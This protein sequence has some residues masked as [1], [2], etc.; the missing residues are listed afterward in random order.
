MGENKELLLKIADHFIEN[1]FDEDYLGVQQ[2]SWRL[3]FQAN[4]PDPSTGEWFD[5]E[6]PD[7]F[8]N[9]REI[10]EPIEEELAANIP[11]NLPKL[12]EDWEKAEAEGKKEKVIKQTLET[13]IEACQKAIN[14]Q[15]EIDRHQQLIEKDIRPKIELLQKEVGEAVQILDWKFP[16]LIETS[17][18]ISQALKEMPEEKLI[19]AVKENKV[20]EEIL[21]PAIVRGLELKGGLLTDSDFEEVFGMTKEVAEAMG[22]GSDLEKIGKETAAELS[23]DKAIQENFNQQVQLLDLKKFT[24]ERREYLERKVE[25]PAYDPGRSF[26]DPIPLAEVRI[27]EFVHQLLNLPAAANELRTNLGLTN[28]EIDLLV[29][30]ISRF[31]SSNT[32]FSQNPLLFTQ[33]ENQLTASIIKTFSNAFEL[34]LR[35]TAFHGGIA[36]E[37]PIIGTFSQIS[38]AIRNSIPFLR[39]KKAKAAKRI[40]DSLKQDF[41]KPP[42]ALIS[43]IKTAALTNYG[44]VDQSIERGNPLGRLP[45]YVLRSISTLDERFLLETPL[46]IFVDEFQ[47]YWKE[48]YHPPEDKKFTPSHKA[49]IKSYVEFLRAFEKSN[50]AGF[51]LFRFYQKHLIG[52]SWGKSVAG[53]FI[54]YPDYF[55]HFPFIFGKYWLQ[56]KWSLKWEFTFKP[57]VFD[58]IISR[59]PGIGR[60]LGFLY[61]KDTWGLYRGPIYRIKKKIVDFTLQKGIKGTGELLHTLGKRLGKTRLGQTLMGWGK[62]L[63]D[64]AGTGGLGALFLAFYPFFKKVL[65]KILG[66]FGLIALAILRWAT[67]YGPGAIA[68][69]GIG[70][71]A[72]IPAGIK[73]GTVVFKATFPFLGPFAIIPSVLAGG[74]TWLGFQIAGAG[75]GILATKLWLSIKGFFGSIFSSTTAAVETA[76]GTAAAEIAGGAGGFSAISLTSNAFLAPASLAGIAGLAA[77]TIIT[78]SS[79]YIMSTGEKY[80]SEYIQIQKGF[81]IN[82]SPQETTIFENDEVI[83][84]N[85]NYGFKVAISGKDLHDVKVNDKIKIIKENV[86]VYRDETTNLGDMEAGSDWETNYTIT[87]DDQFRD[88]YVS[89]TVTVTSEEGETQS[90]TLTLTLGQ[91]PLPDSVTLARRIVDKLIHDCPGLPREMDGVILN[92]SSWPTAKACLE[93]ANIPS[94]VL[95]RFNSCIAAHYQP[96]GE[97]QCVSFVVAVTMG[98]LPDK[99]AAKYYC[100]QDTPGYTLSNNWNNIQPGDIIAHKV[101]T[102]GHVAIVVSPPTKN[103]SGKLLSIEVAE[104]IGTNGVVQYRDISETFLASRYCGYLRKN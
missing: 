42:A 86:V 83:G 92:E 30:D 38:I 6:N 22:A 15:W 14:A 93:D 55:L 74:L 32:F 34:H 19:Q 29:L 97:L 64:I 1:P 31:I 98:D 24:A 52:I 61:K 78:S 68:G 8:E 80:G 27:Q 35:R 33:P 100:T 73:V 40:V 96:R 58:A 17:D 104:A 67:T 53:F 57:K 84:Q 7:F 77:Y 81:D 25:D 49:A 45:S 72:G 23:G 9:I 48:K 102:T 16:Q 43:T 56:S 2:R 66:F 85:L 101:G 39:T 11:A 69:W 91:P 87:P 63:L 36:G 51:K 90:L 76:A 88:S 46:D 62:K 103:S 60:I 28:T 37:L 71:V 65:K 94:F 70:A 89:N 10:L 12:V 95:N 5:I 21:K 18:K 3:F 54:K 13:E 79:A 47:K 99:A 75:L 82:G 26:E 20:E 4:F 59:T 44:L 50:P 41:Q